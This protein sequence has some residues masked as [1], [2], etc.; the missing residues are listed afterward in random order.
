[1]MVSLRDGVRNGLFQEGLFSGRI[2]SVMD[3]FNGGLVQIGI[4][5]GNNWFIGG[6]GASN[7]WFMEGLV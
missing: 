2:V 5:P 7:D 6:I 1:M 3:W 4:V